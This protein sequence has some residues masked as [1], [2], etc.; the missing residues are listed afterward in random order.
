M[1][2]SWFFHLPVWREKQKEIWKN[3][4][5]PKLDENQNSPWK[6]PKKT[7]LIK[8]HRVKQ[9]LPSPFPQKSF[10]DYKNDGKIR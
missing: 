8:G 10:R 9:N 3:I 4:G 7:V 6:R 5:K 2:N 1:Q